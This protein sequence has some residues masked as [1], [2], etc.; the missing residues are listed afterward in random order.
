[1][2]DS[3]TRHARRLARLRGLYAIVGDDDPIGNARAVI[4]G[5]A[6]VVQVRMKRSPAGAVLAAARAIASLARDRA[7]V[8]VNDRAD[9]ALL[10]GADGVHVGEEDLPTAEA[11]RLLGPELLVG[12]STRTLE[13]AREAIRAGADHVGFGPMFGTRSK[14]LAAA[15]R[16]LDALGEVARGLGAPVVAIGGIG[17]ESV[18]GVAAAGAAA[19]AII[20]DLLARGDVRERAALLAARFAAGVEEAR[21]AGERA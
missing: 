9:L 18:A 3:A 15:P 8:I 21:V 12:R 6:G 13:E 20:E 4:E 1:M 14:E 19:A 10:A 7:L 17:L 5:G 11:R 2:E 16:G